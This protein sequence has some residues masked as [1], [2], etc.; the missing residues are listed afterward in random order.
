MKGYM[1][2]SFRSRTNRT[3]NTQ[4]ARI[5]NQPKY[6]I[7][8]NIQELEY[9]QLSKAMLIISGHK[10]DSKNAILAGAA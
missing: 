10:E 2:A 1:R 5:N 6:T 4:S 9:T 7:S 8:Q 3:Q